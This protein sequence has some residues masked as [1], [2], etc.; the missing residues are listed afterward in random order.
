MGE[1]PLATLVATDLD[2][3]VAPTSE[4]ETPLLGLARGTTTCTSG[5]TAAGGCPTWWR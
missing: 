1:Q 2:E 5:A 4:G 3:E